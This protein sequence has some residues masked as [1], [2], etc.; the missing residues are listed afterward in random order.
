MG[1][2]NTVACLD[3]GQATAWQQS[4][5][6]LAPGISYLSLFVG[7]EG[8]IAAAGASTA[9]HWI[10][11]SEDIGA[12]WRSP[13][14]EDAP[15]IFVSF[16]SLKD[17]ASPGAPTAEVV[18]VVD[19]AAFAP[20]LDHVDAARAEEYLAL[21]AWVEERM[22]AQ[23]LRHFPA[24]KPMLRFHELSTP[25]TQQRYVRSPEGAMYGIEMTAERLISPALH[26]RTPLPGLLLAGQDV[27]SPGVPG[28]FMGGLMAAAAI[29][30]ALWRQLSN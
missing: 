18:A 4:V 28:A 11:E 26:V 30:P 15:G 12:V 24:L 22:L 5:R 14:D 19:A 17:P 16:P 27:T 9:N 21:K 23:F 3:A 2:A 29:E 1:V 6:T 7:L 8:D 13:A 20:W 10:Y 25:V